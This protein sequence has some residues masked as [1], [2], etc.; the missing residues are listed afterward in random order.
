M[1]VYDAA[2]PRGHLHRDQQQNQ[3]AVLSSRSQA[4]IRMAV[5]EPMGPEQIVEGLPKQEAEALHANF[6]DALWPYRHACMFQLINVIAACH[7]RDTAALEMYKQGI[8]ASYAADHGYANFARV[9]GYNF[10]H[11][12]V[13]QLVDECIRV[14]QSTGHPKLCC[15]DLGCGRK[16]PLH[17]LS[18]DSAS[19][20]FVDFLKFKS[21]PAHAFGESS[22]D[23]HEF[24]L[25]F[26]DAAALQANLQ[27]FD[28]AISL[29]SF[30]QLNT[31]AALAAAAAIARPDSL[32]IAATFINQE[33]GAALREIKRV[34]E[35]GLLGWQV[36]AIEEYSDLNVAF[37][38]LQLKQ[39]LSAARLDDGRNQLDP[40]DL[41][42]LASPNGVFTRSEGPNG[43]VIARPRTA[44]SPMVVQSLQAGDRPAVYEWWLEWEEADGTVRRSHVYRGSANYP[45]FRLAH[46]H[47]RGLS[48]VGPVNATSRAGREFWCELEAQEFEPV[49]VWRKLDIL[50][51]PRRA[52]PFQ[53]TTLLQLTEQHRIDTVMLANFYSGQDS[54]CNAFNR[55]PIAAVGPTI[56]DAAFRFFLFLF[57]VPLDSL[58]NQTTRT[59]THSHAHT[60]AHT[61]VFH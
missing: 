26:T 14:A 49:L 52:T 18:E 58:P 28:V 34:G 40:L 13:G 39:Q 7:P 25:D 21:T 23:R 10:M 30:T 31:H 17:Q 15:L 57:R 59:C 2:R 54:L 43:I 20:A 29:S 53:I 24:L 33:R 41:D 42:N 16:S 4:R 50:E 47:F 8:S 6:S 46:Q 38:S 5:D 44:H 55:N 27:P 37:V 61:Q 12:R 48:G 9:H 45:W 11:Q 1:Y 22:A 51:L 56:G 35:S 32:L 3:P 36:T 60:H 19:C